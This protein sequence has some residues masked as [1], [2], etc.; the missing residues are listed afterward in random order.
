MKVLSPF[1]IKIRLRKYLFI[2]SLIIFWCSYLG[3]LAVQLA[4]IDRQEY[5]TTSYTVDRGQSLRGVIS[6]LYPQQSYW[7]KRW[8]EWVARVINR[9]SIQLGEYNISAVQNYAELLEL[10][11]YGR[12]VYRSVT[13][14]EGWTFRQALQHLEQNTNLMKD[15]TP[16]QIPRSKILGSLTNPEGLIAADTYYYNSGDSI[17]DL[18]QVAHQK[19]VNQLQ[20]LWNNNRVELPYKLAY[21]ALIMASIVE[22]ETGLASERPQ[23]A[24]VFTR[25]LQKKMRLQTD[26]TVIYGLGDRYKGDIKR[27]HLLEKTAYNT[28]FIKGLPPTPIA[29]VGAEALEAVFSPT[30]DMTLYFVAK[31]DG[32]HYFSYSLAEHQQA[33]RK[34]QIEKRVKNYRSA[35]VQ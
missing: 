21:E 23:I 11:H 31:G 28:Y 13:L 12:V 27:K 34:Y 16:W 22:K 7:A 25:R 1:I 18:I 10:L 24:G 26:P 8:K 19:L 35:P 4:L 32:S 15:A 17:N 30:A 2:A 20:L 3:F 6:D 14:V 33:V 5:A 9:S 29:I